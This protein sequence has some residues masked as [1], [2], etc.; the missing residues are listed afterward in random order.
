MKRDLHLN[1]FAYW[2]CAP[3]DSTETG[4]CVEY[5]DQSR[6][7]LLFSYN[8]NLIYKF[9]YLLMVLLFNNLLSYT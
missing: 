7:T 4:R 5:G 3:N 1:T 2:E 8:R 9:S 6:T